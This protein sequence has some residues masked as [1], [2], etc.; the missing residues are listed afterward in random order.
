MH[1]N[2][3]LDRDIRCAVLTVS[4]T[5]TVETDKGGQ[6]VKSLLET[7][8]TEIQPDHYAIVKD[9]KGEI[10]AQLDKWLAEDVEV[11]VTTGGTGIAPRDVTIETVAPM[12][13]KEIEGFGELFRYLSYVEDV[14]TRALLSRAVGG[15]IDNKLIFCLPGSTGAVK[16]GLNKLIL[17]ELNHLIH[18]MNK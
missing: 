7:I 14:G 17:P 3:K 4:D 1:T 2:V 13:T 16:L 10:R 12:L 8:N 9:D 5:R 11:I 15:T 18:E 6:L